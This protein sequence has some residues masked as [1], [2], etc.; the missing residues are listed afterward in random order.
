MNELDDVIIYILYKIRNIKQNI[1]ITRMLKLLYLIDLVA[2]A[3]TNNKITNVK[4]YYYA[5]GP[6]SNRI[7][8]ELNKLVDKKIII[9]NKFYTK[10]GISHDYGLNNYNK[11]NF[12]I[13]KEQKDIIDEI[14]TK[15]GKMDLDKLLDI[16]Y[17]TRPMLVH[18]PGEVLI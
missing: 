3:R 4:Y 2:L 10:N 13:N 5:F 12:N 11:N 15:Y 17:I 8:E 9:D 1:G 6:Y 18:F 16:I 7:I 14:L